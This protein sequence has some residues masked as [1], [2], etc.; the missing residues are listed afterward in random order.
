MS[1]NSSAPIPSPTKKLKMG[2]FGFPLWR[3]PNGTIN[4]TDQELEGASSSCEGWGLGCAALVVFGVAA[5]LVIA[6]FH[7]AYDSFL[8]QWG[9]AAANALIALGIVGEVL[10]SRKDARIQTELRDRSNRRLAVAINDAAEANTR[11]AEAE[12]QARRLSGPRMVDVQAFAKAIAGAIPAKVEI[13]VS[14]D[15]AD[16]GWVGAFVHGCLKTAGWQVLWLQPSSSPLIPAALEAHGN[17]WGISV[18]ANNDGDFQ[19]PSFTALHGAL[20]AAMAG[21]QIHGLGVPG[22][23]KGILRLVIAGRP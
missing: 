12:L 5:E 23:A 4:A 13:F 10:F 14:P 7:P 19:S 3:L 18:V 20:K 6:G 17:S 2:F 8:E 21:E 11:A 15:C 16:C 1:E 22:M 9:S